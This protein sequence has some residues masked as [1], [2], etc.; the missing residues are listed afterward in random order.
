MT[1]IVDVGRVSG[2]TPGTS[3]VNESASHAGK[4]D[5]RGPGD[6]VEVEW[7]GSWWPAVLVERR[8]DLWL[9]HYEGY[10]DEWDETVG[11]DRIRLRGVE[12]VVEEPEDET[13][14]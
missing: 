2:A 11:P 8:G 14:P 10:G 3:S 12:G 6:L 4:D 5:G 9:I 7:R 13:D 1:L